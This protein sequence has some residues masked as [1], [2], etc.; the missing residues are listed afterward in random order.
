MFLNIYINILLG[1]KLPVNGGWGAAFVSVTLL[2]VVF[3]FIIRRRIRQSADMQKQLR[4]RVR[5]KTKELEEQKER[6]EHSEKVK[7]Q[8]LA[9]MS[10]EIRTP[11][12]AI[13]HANRL[14]LENDPKEDQLKYLNIIKQSSDNLLI[15]IN[16]ILD[17]SK[18]EA[19]RINF[20]VLDFNLREQVQSVVNTLKIYADEKKLT[21]EYHI[22]DTT[23]EILTGDPHR[24]M[25]ILLNL[26]GNALK[27][28]EKGYVRI[29]V[30]TVT[31]T[32]E[33]ATL[34]FSVID[35]GIGIAQ[36]K[37]DYI[38]DMF[39]QASSS[40]TRKFGGTGLGLAICKRLVERQGGSIHVLSALGKGSTFYFLLHFKIPEQKTEVAQYSGSKNME[41]PKLENLHILL[42]E[43]NEFNQMVAVDTI[44]S[45]IKGVKIDVAKTGKEVIEKIVKTRYDVILMDIQ[46]PEMDG[47]EATRIIRNM[48]DKKI[49]AIPIIAMTASVIKSEV[50]KCFESGMNAFIGKPFHVDELIDK[51][52][53][54]LQK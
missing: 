10:H 11:M 18:I 54:Q 23:P 42:A 15:I 49:H 2:S 37:L 44:E 36:D 16:D 53:S 26:T 34:K 38:F 12:N 24:L 35:T 28:T 39:T 41:K 27:F 7:E 40:T 22:D 9:N 5:E 29:A 45:N 8:F 47:Y 4:E 33:E 1:L 6:A 19:G 48:S 17:L 3:L 25:Q 21:L 46:M 31:Q 32:A 13:V 30:E 14:L 52:A 50:D 43:D 20:E 51:I